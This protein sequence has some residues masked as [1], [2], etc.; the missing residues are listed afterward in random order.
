MDVPYGKRMA[1]DGVTVE[2][3]EAEQAMIAVLKEARAQG[4]PWDVICKLVQEAGLY[5]DSQLSFS[6]HD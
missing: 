2:D 4:I 3:D 6:A 5:G 1:T